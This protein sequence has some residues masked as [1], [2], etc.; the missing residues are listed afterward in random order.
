MS[1]TN[2]ELP[3]A[4]Q[5]VDL[6]LPLRTRN[7]TCARRGGHVAARQSVRTEGPRVDRRYRRP[8]VWSEHPRSP[9]EAGPWAILCY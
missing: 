2:Y 3:P 6:L 5:L 4:L 8:R 7:F 9:G 1:S